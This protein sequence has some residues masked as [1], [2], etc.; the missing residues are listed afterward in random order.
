MAKPRNFKA[1]RVTGLV[2]ITPQKTPTPPKRTPPVPV[3]RKI[4]V[5]MMSREKEDTPGVDR[6]GGDA[7]GALIGRDPHRDMTG[8]LQFGDVI[9][10]PNAHW[11]MGHGDSP[12]HGVTCTNRNISRGIWAID[13]VFC[14]LLVRTE[15]LSFAP[16]AKLLVADK[17]Y[18]SMEGGLGEP[19]DITGHTDQ[20]LES[21]TTVVDSI[22]HRVLAGLWSR[23]CPPPVMSSP[24]QVDRLAQSCL[25][26]PQ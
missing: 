21:S 1:D 22:R 23:T 26:C 10:E 14:E 13:P 7:R 24:A 15:A 11:P 20:P 16:L 9:M 3:C 12:R 6:A 8:S 2:P 25:C 18:C 5:D 19:P 4:L 17:C